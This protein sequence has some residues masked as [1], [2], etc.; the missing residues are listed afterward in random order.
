MG[1][2]NLT[3]CVF[4]FP[5]LAPP[6]SSPEQLQPLIW[7]C[8]RPS[9]A[10]R[11][12]SRP[13]SD[14]HPY[15]MT[16]R[17]RRQAMVPRPLEACLEAGLGP[18]SLSN[19]TTRTTSAMVPRPLEACLEAVLGPPSLSNDTTLTTSAMVPRPLEACLEAVLGQLSLSNDTTRR[20]SAM[21]PRP[22][23][24][25]LE[26]GLGPPSLANDTTRTTSGDG[27]E[28]P[29]GLPRGWPRTT[30]PIK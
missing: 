29:R 16:P 17:G 10:S 26:A 8:G 3:L 18:P 4:G 22:L 24:A 11:L 2:S 5:A 23:E 27:P 15:Q 12:A 21:V 6:T 9:L 1:K 19:D 25:C 30:F 28:A 7:G 20:T 13:A 14:H